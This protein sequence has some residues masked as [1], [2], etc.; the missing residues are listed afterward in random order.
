MTLKDT[1][2]D[3]ILYYIIA[4][5]TFIELNYIYRAMA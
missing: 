3:I 5:I 2:K 1:M 4:F